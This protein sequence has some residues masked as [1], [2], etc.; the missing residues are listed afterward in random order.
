MI[1]PFGSRS[2]FCYNGRVFTKEIMM[3][4][5]IDKRG[6][7]TLV[8]D[9]HFEVEITPKIYDDGY[10]LTKRVLDDPLKII[11]IRDIRLPLSEKE[12]LKEAKKLL[13]TEYESFSWQGWRLPTV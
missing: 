7:G 12:I 13:K 5:K 9:D 1:K 3:F 8:S 2:R 10:T 4:E 6:A 11:E